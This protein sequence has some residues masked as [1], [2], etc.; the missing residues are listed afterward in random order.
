VY[1]GDGPERMKYLIDRTKLI[2]QAFPGKR[3]IKKY[4]KMEEAGD[5][6]FA[7]IELHFECSMKFNFMLKIICD[8]D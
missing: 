2:G 1:S 3:Y 4:T 7:N 6:C 5:C 8:V